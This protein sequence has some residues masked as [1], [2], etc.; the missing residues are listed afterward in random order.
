[1]MKLTLST[2]HH[3]LQYLAKLQGHGLFLPI[4]RF[5]PENRSSKGTGLR[6]LEAG[7]SISASCSH[8]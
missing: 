4:F 6:R 7:E 3:A 2:Q 5:R 8:L 1:M